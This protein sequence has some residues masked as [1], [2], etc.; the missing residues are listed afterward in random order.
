[1]V[2]LIETDARKGIHM[3]GNA[4]LYTHI[5][6]FIYG[7]NLYLH[8]LFLL[9]AIYVV[10]VLITLVPAHLLEVRY[11]TP[12]VV[13]ALINLPAAKMGNDKSG[14]DHDNDTNY[15]IIEVNNHS[16]KI[17]NSEQSIS[18]NRRKYLLV[19][20]LCCCV[21]NII[22]IYVFLYRPFTWNDAS[23]ARF[24]Y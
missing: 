5:Y 16:T 18:I 1:M 23:I 9:Q 24:M 2:E 19:S 21:I 15:D 4:A 13:I 11:F 22:T 17:Q 6:L 3:A 10:A 7:D 12:A 8:K 14:V 20:I